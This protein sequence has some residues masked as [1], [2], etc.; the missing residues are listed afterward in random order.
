[1]KKILAR[2]CTELDRWP[3]T[4]SNKQYKDSL[5]YKYVAPPRG[6][7]TRVKRRIQKRT[8]CGSFVY[9]YV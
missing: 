5:A 3:A 1:M 7:W 6:L 8:L 9:H 2:Y 4:Q